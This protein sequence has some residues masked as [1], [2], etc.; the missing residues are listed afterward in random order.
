MVMMDPKNIQSFVINSKIYKIEEKTLDKENEA[1][2]EITPTI[3][4]P[5]LSL[6]SPPWAGKEKTITYT[7]IRYYSHD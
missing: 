5:V 6:Q 2:I 1:N 7:N 3:I 4:T